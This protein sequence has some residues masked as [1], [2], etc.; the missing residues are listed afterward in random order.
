[1]DPHAGGSATLLVEWAGRLKWTVHGTAT[2]I[3]PDAARE[4]VRKG[5]E[6]GAVVALEDLLVAAEL[7]PVW[8]RRLKV[9]AI[10]H[11]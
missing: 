6:K 7:S 10:D 3:T 9:C 8:A 5:V 11:R 1:M 4:W 2:V